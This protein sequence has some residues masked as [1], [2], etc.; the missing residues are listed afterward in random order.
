MEG[1]RGCV[2]DSVKSLATDPAGL[3][4]WW[5]QPHLVGTVVGSSPGY[6]RKADFG[7]GAGGILRYQ[8]HF[9]TQ[10]GEFSCLLWFGRSC[11]MGYP[12]WEVLGDRGVTV[13]LGKH[14]R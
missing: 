14:L 10:K 13:A 1:L 2:C 6:G 9:S 12:G 11:P 5:Q 4:G 7:R 3:C 8:K